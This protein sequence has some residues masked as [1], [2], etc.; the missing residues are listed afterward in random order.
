[1]CGIFV[2]FSKNGHT[3]PKQKCVT[4]SKNLLNRGPDFHKF[5]FFQKDNL[6]ISNTILSIT[7]EPGKNK[8][9]TS[10]KNKILI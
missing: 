8:N 6:F 4:V 10:S 9:I 3:L 7:G 5:S 1:M 2:A